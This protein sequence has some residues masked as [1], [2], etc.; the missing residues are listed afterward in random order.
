MLHF[1]ITGHWTEQALRLRWTTSTRV[2][3]EDVE[4]AI[5][6]EW[7]LAKI[8]LAEHLFDGAM[9]RLE[10]WS[11]L[12]GELKLE[13][14]LTSYKTFLGTNLNHRGKHFPNAALANS[15]G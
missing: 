1:L 10:R 12:P 8:Q 6:R 2:K 9:C 3:R 11:S 7:A 5:E 4:Q 15:L 14:S 13:L